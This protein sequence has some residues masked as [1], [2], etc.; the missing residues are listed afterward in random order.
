M[1]DDSRYIAYVHTGIWPSPS[2]STVFVTGTA[3]GLS[4]H[5]PCL[6]IIRNGSPQSTGEVFRTLTGRDVPEHLTVSR[7]GFG[8]SLPGHARFYLGAFRTI[9]NLDRTKRIRAVITRSIGFLPY[10]TYLHARYRIPCLFETH[11]FF[12]DLS[13]RNDLPRSLKNMKRSQFERR[14]LPRT[15]GI[16]CLTESQRDLLM[17]RYPSVESVVAP[18]GLFS[19]ERRPEPPEKL[20]CYIGSLEPHKGVGLILDALS[21]IVDRDVKLLVIGG[22]NEREK[23]SLIELAHL[24]GAADRVRVTSWIH[25]SDIGHHIGRC[26]AGLVPLRDTPFNRHITS[27]LKILDCFSRCVPVIA[28]DLPSVRFYVK[29]GT[30]GLLFQPD[31]ASS[32]AETIDRYF[33]ANLFNG[34]ADNIRRDALQYLWTER[35]R[36]INDFIHNIS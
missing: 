35:G 13:A 24:V 34:F 21:R 4:H 28:S 5:S 14:F 16:V 31:S 26:I 12:G 33:A 18:T 9:R 11:D 20:L 2:P 27:P 15:S 30:N 1:T 32:L 29:D 17:K 6:L 8:K 25:H 19:V 10:L 23:R 3:W 22:K 36:I 7:T